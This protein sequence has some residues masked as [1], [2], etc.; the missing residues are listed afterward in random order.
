MGIMSE[1]IILEMKGITKKFGN[2]KALDDMSISVKCGEVHAIIGENGAGKSTLMKVL[3]GYYPAG[4][5]DGEIFIEGKI[6]KFANTSDSIKVGIAMVYQ[7][8]ETLGTLTIS[9]NIF[10]AALKYN[11]L[12]LVDYKAMF[13]ETERV[14][15]SV[16]LDADPKE[17]MG[18]LNTSQQQLV[19]FAKA[20][21]EGAKLLILDEPTSSLTKTEVNKLMEV[22]RR[23]KSEGITFIYIT[24]KL[25]EVF[26]LAD[27]C[28]VIRDGKSI[29]TLS[30][31]EFEMNKIISMMVGRNIGDIYP[32]RSP[33]I[34]EEKLRVE[35]MVIKHPRVLGRNVVNRVSF[36][37]RKGEIL[38][39]AGMVGAGRSEILNGIYGAMKRESGDIYI[40]GK[41]VAINNVKDALAYDISMLTEDRHESG[42][43]KQDK[44]VK[45]NLLA[46]ILKKMREGLFISDK[47]SIET[48]DKMMKSLQ[49]K[50][51]SINAMITSLSGGNQQ[52]VC[53]GRGLLSEPKILLLDE[54]TRGVD[55]G[56]K[57]Q[58]YNLIYE[59][60][61]KGISIIV[62]SS[63]LPELLNIC[64]RF[65]VIA[66]G[67]VKGELS[68][69]EVSEELV[70]KYAVQ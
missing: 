31:T 68:R 8:I 18:K 4:T 34:G 22:I 51:S 43:F 65:L 61:D 39:L 66:S 55:V 38:G 10:S 16:N 32:K 5:Y 35:N 9:E 41:K 11:K 23:L 7:E 14:L 13:A 50:A 44:A 6:A 28:T 20:V 17:L 1:N 52:K 19:M 26:E 42:L 69:E 36:N 53:L 21:H 25:D 46:T 48:A 49:I 15:E 30:N 33:E 27:T 12:G 2:F 57:N 64:D 45:Q 60:A 40:D 47:K 62:I 56:T 3:H 54:P 29:C 24:H 58:I 59:L 67:E 70:M 63:E 37:L